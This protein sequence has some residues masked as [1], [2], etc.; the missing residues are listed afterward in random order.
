MNVARNIYSI[1]GR[2][3]VMVTRRPKAIFGGRFNTIAEAVSARDAI[4]SSTPKRRPGAARKA[5]RRTVRLLREERKAAGLCMSCG[6]EAPAAGLL[7]CR[8]CL[9]IARDSRRTARARAGRIFSP[10]TNNQ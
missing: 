7:S 5:N 10:T 4:E 2:Y 8:A 3:K 6:D 1:E 9:D